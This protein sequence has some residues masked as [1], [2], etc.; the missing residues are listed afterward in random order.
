MKRP[1]KEDYMATPKKPAAAA[2]KPAAKPKTAAAKPKA[3]AAKTTVAK[4]K[5]NP[6]KAESTSVKTEFANMKDKAAD[7]AREAADKGKDKASEALG[8]FGQILRDSAEQI[9]EKVG[10]QYGDYARKA[11]DAV[12][13]FA[14]KMDAK[15]VDDI[16][17]DTRQFI[18]KSP[19]V[20]IG[21]AAAIGFVLARLVRSGRN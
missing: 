4:A 19:G 6:G 2:K 18:R 17:E 13:D 20:A 14:T 7:R 11:A 12:D 10:A 9:D 5:P 16:L 1:D 21:A 15:Q 3:A 8:G